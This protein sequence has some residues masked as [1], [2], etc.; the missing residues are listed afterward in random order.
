MNELLD[1][2]FEAAIR[3]A[4]A[5]DA[6]RAPRAPEWEGPQTTLAT[7]RSSPRWVTVA[8]SVLVMVALGTMAFLVT[9]ADDPTTS[10]GTP[11]TQTTIVTPS[12]NPQW[13]PMASPSIEPRSGY[14]SVQTDNGW[15]VWGGWTSP[16]GEGGEQSANDG[17][18][19]DGVSDTWTTLPTAPIT[20]DFRAAYGVWTGTEVIVVV[21]YGGPRL[22]AFDPATF[23]WR[24]IPVSAEQR[25]AWPR[26][27]G[28]FARGW[29]R[30]VGGKLVMFFPNTATGRPALLVVDPSTG[31]WTTGAPP[32]MTTDDLVIGVAA[33][34]GQFFIAGAG[35]LNSN[36]VCSR[37]STPL[38]IYDVAADTWNTSFLPHGNWQPAFIAWTGSRLLAAGG[39][40]CGSD[41]AT[42]TTAAFDPTTTIWTDMAEMSEDLLYTVVEPLVSDGRVIVAGESGT[43]SVYYLDLD[44]WWSGPA[45][46]PGRAFGDL[47]LAAVAG[48]MLTW[49][50]SALEPQEDG[51]FSC[52]VPDSRTLALPIPTNPA[53][54]SP[55]PPTPVD[56]TEPIATASCTTGTYLVVEGDTPLAV[57]TKFGL[58]LDEFAVA[59]ADTPGFEAFAAG[60]KVTIPPASVNVCGASLVV[61]VDPKASTE[62]LELVR[63]A[64][65]GL[66]APF[67]P[68]LT[69]SV[70]GPQGAVSFLLYA[71][72]IFE[73]PAAEQT[74]LESIAAD[75]KSL[76][77]VVQVDVHGIPVP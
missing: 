66:S 16:T 10:D 54:A 3:A 73:T 9:R 77:M 6:E 71:D 12:T 15:F 11:P 57:A 2:D 33:S 23:G 27:D 46:F 64:L 69:R 42:R 74:R 21:A 44:K 18:Y 5:H 51:S 29:H 48:R 70:T 40:I 30:F 24:D 34:S 43:P 61:H 36:S 65:D 37:E 25:A 4:L 35:Q 50:A 20:N 38:Y 26:E 32:P 8:A 13:A 67:D 75:L 68:D 39:K 58:T 52:C 45:V 41:I 28:H 63:N 59:N 1:H 31:E 72:Q 47:H 56:S 7:P 62:Q 14:V 22:A 60:T 53:E 17:A 76:P 55:T 49:S 19:Y